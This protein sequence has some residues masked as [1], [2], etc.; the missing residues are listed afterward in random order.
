MGKIDVQSYRA[1]TQV[2]NFF[3][4]S[5]FR[6]GCGSVLGWGK[7]HTKKFHIKDI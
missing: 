7:K 3:T 4:L 5:N 6:T 1:H 2:L